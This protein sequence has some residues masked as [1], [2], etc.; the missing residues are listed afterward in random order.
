MRFHEIDNLSA[1]AYQFFAGLDS[2]DHES[3]AR[4]MAR[5]GIWH[6]QGVEL[7]G[8]VAVLEAL[9]QRDSTRN[10]AHLVTNLWI[11]HETEVTARLRYYMTAYESMRGPD[12][13]VSAPKLLGVRDCTDD[14][15][16]EDGQ[17]RIRCKKSNLIMLGA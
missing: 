6:R 3:T 17:W 2:R 11:E 10:T 4:L 9:R 14:L 5:E 15:L 16:M 1:V 12:G 7:V 13:R 8:P